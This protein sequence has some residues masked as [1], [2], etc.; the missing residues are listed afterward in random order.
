MYW[1]DYADDR[2]FHL[3]DP[4]TLKL[5]FI[6]NPYRM[7]RKLFYNDTKTNYHKVNITQ[8]KDSYIKLIVEDK[9][10]NFMF[11]RLIERL[12][13]L[14]IHDL[15]V[16]EDS[17]L[18]FEDGEENIECEDTLTILNKYIEDTEDIQCDKNGIKNII[19]SIYVEACEVQ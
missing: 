16:I 5:G 19:K 13:D 1:N 3:F 14:G 6:K 17:S 15:K 7:F 18:N 10:N 11:E 4:E 9:K 2:G 8:Y 12:Y